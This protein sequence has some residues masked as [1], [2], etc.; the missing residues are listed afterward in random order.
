M[1]ELIERITAAGFVVEFMPNHV[2][3]MWKMSKGVDV[4]T[5]GHKEDIEVALQNLTKAVQ[6]A[7]RKE[8][9]I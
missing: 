5:I 3:K 4:Y 6:T 9:I 7:H 1:K 8:W 2:I